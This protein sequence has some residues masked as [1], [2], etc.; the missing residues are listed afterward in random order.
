M[1]ETIGGLL[2]NGFKKTDGTII[3]LSDSSKDILQNII[4]TAEQQTLIDRGQDNKIDDI[5]SRLD[6]K[7]ELDSS[8]DLK[9][10]KNIESIST[11]KVLIDN[12]A[13][14][15][16]KNQKDILELQK[17]NSK[18][19]AILAWVAIILSL[20]SLGVSLASKF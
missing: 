4:F 11:N 13:E 5:S 12:N 18:S 6:K 10:Q 2:V 3:K 16:A 1:I 9:I 20:V 17:R 19:L 7:D 14:L 8:Q 15:I